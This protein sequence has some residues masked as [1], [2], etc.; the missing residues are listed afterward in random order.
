[1]FIGNPN[2]SRPGRRKY[3]YKHEVKKRLRD[4]DE[5]G[6]TTTD[7][8]EEQQSEPRDDELDEDLTN[9]SS[10]RDGK[11]S[12]PQTS[13]SSESSARKKGVSKQTK[14]TRQNQTSSK[15][16]RNSNDLD[17][18]SEA[19]ATLW[20]L[21]EGGMAALGGLLPGISPDPTSRGRG[22]YQAGDDFCAEP[23]LSFV[24][25][26]STGRAVPVGGRKRTGNM[27]DVIERSQNMVYAQL[28]DN[29]S[30]NNGEAFGRQHSKH[31]VL[32]SHLRRHP[33]QKKS[34]SKDSSRHDYHYSVNTHD[35]TRGSSRALHLRGIDRSSK[36]SVNRRPFSL[37]RLAED[38]RFHQLCL[39]AAKSLHRAQGA[40]F[41][42]DYHISIDQDIEI[43]V[44]ELK[45][46]LGCTYDIYC[47]KPRCG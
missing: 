38:P 3:K 13:H 37:E 40:E 20:N 35:S 34:H 45:L 10:N 47:A 7:R 25:C 2:T 41:D 19:E 12:T 29:V 23:M 26:S 28:A 11:T 14:N 9:A 4:I 15:S 44:V 22:D 32:S 30:V 39:H 18:L 36:V 21:V 24:D 31:T 8:H 27:A 16:T 6:T 5:M 17:G 33:S 43:S 46:P 1:L 42:E